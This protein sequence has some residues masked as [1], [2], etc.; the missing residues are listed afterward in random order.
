MM[1]ITANHSFQELTFQGQRCLPYQE[2]IS[3]RWLTSTKSGNQLPSKNQCKR[4]H[5]IKIKIFFSMIKF[6]FCY[7]HLNINTNL[8][9]EIGSEI[10]LYI[11]YSKSS[12]K[13]KPLLNSMQKTKLMKSKNILKIKY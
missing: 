8:P 4:I 11:I 9:K 7:T 6:Q 3:G 1:K 12:I 13:P 5:K 10:K 2:T